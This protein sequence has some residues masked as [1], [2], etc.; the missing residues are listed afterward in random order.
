MKSALEGVR[1][2]LFDLDGTLYQDGKAIPG[3]ADTVRAL[4]ARRFATCFATNTTGRSRATLAEK[5]TRLGIPAGI[6]D[7]LQPP[8]LAARF[9]KARGCSCAHILVREDTFGEFAGIDHVEAGAE[10]VVVGDLGD[11]WD[12]KRL[13][14]AFRLVMDGA[15]IIAL[16]MTRSWMAP[17]GLRLDAG[18]FVAALEYATAKKALVLGKPAPA[19][20]ELAIRTLGL[21]PAQIAMVGDDIE[22]DVAGAQQVGIAGILVRTGKFQPGDLSGPATPDLVI[23]SVADLVQMTAGQ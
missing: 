22:V 14:H 10:F 15:D 9:L 17:D 1:A 8:Y 12:F 11:G 23:D 21:A 5:L 19:F 20:F 7:I 16:G 2:F 4:R 3:A 6:G 18:P 13:N